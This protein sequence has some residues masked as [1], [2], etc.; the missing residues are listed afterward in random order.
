MKKIY[1]ACKVF[2]LGIVIIVMLTACTP[3]TEDNFDKIQIGMTMS[4]VT[5]LIGPPTSEES[6]SFLGL[7]GTTAV[8]KNQNIEITILFFNE[9]VQM[10]GLKQ[11]EHKNPFPQKA[12]NFETIT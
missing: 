3:V 8:W 10:K 7:T 1:R 12:Y 5:T 9:K 11:V 4:Q 6:V 2:L